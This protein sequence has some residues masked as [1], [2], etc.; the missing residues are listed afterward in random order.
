MAL[1]YLRGER[2]FGKPDNHPSPASLLARLPMRML[3]LVRLSDSEME[4]VELV[5]A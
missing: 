4:M 3:L 1:Y 2:T 5:I